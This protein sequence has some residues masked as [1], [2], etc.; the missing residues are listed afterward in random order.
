MI[1]NSTILTSLYLPLYIL[2]II[3]ISLL[4]NY[5]LCIILFG[6]FV[7]SGRIGKENLEC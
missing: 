1:E 4:G 6:L 3:D 5:L 7:L 2:N